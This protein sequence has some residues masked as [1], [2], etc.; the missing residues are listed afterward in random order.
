MVTNHV[1]KQGYRWN[2]HHFSHLH[3]SRTP[4]PFYCFTALVSVPPPPSLALPAA[5]TTCPTLTLR[6]VG[7]LGLTHRTGSAKRLI[8]ELIRI[9]TVVGATFTWA[10]PVLY[11]VLDS[12][13]G[14]L[15]EGDV[16]A[17]QQI[18]RRTMPALRSL[19]LLLFRDLIT[20]DR[21][22]DFW[23]RIWEHIQFEYQF[24]EVL[25]EVFPLDNPEVQVLATHL[26]LICK[27]AQLNR[28]EAPKNL[29]ALTPGVIAH[30]VRIWRLFV[31]DESFRNLRSVGPNL[32]VAFSNIPLIR[33]F[34]H[35]PDLIAGAGGELSDLVSL[36]LDYL[37]LAI[38]D[39]GALLPSIVIFVV[40]MASHIGCTG[41][42]LLLEQGLIRRLVKLVT[43]LQSKSA[44]KQ[45]SLGARS[46]I[47]TCYASIA[48]AS[49]VGNERACV[50]ES[51]KSGILLCL[52][53]TC[54]ESQFL[55]KMDANERPRPFWMILLD[56]ISM[57][58]RFRGVVHATVRALAVPQLHKI[59]ARLRDSACALYWEDWLSLAEEVFARAVE[60]DSTP[61]TMRFCDNLDSLLA[62]PSAAVAGRADWVYH[63]SF[64]S[65]LNPNSKPPRNNN[66]LLHLIRHE[67]LTSKTSL[68]REHA[69]CMRGTEAQPDF[70]THWLFLDG[71]V[72]RYVCPTT[73]LEGRNMSDAK[74]ARYAELLQRMRRAP[75]RIQV[76]G[77]AVA[78]GKDLD[79]EIFEFR[80]SSSMVYDGLTALVT[81]LLEGRVDEDEHNRRVDA[82]VEEVEEDLLEI[83][84]S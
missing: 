57:H 62:L 23:P 66:F 50:A 3:T 38:T 36:I 55:L 54:T 41:V 73:Y 5:W 56:R 16:D 28:I 35:T 34:D 25:P 84:S 4:R 46:M 70:V 7:L 9:D 82:L 24:I 8:H 10:L 83:H 49:V 76:H 20:W 74:R 30:L 77:A 80:R 75:G 27:M 58:F 13:A 53:R 19:T 59:V 2:I 65:R 51:V 47:D 68:I 18:G 12:G 31:H 33:D 15:E 1:Y 71:P 81:D 6:A 78:C 29:I 37:D 21:L 61:P 17:A 69:V 14:N 43:A 26:N 45:K 63:K 64:C 44:A 32:D 79:F 72:E 39:N 42:E 40:Y 52:A 22:L 11:Y 48:A 67:Y 60:F